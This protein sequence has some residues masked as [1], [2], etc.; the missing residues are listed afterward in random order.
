MRFRIRPS[1]GSRKSR[2]L[3]LPGWG[4]GVTVPIST[5]PKPSAFHSGSSWAPLSRPAARPMGER[6]RR[7]K[8][9]RAMAGSWR[10]QDALEQDRQAGHPLGQSAQ[11]EAKPVGGFRIQLEKQ[12]TDETVGIQGVSH[13]LSAGKIAISVMP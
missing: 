8:A 4:R 13:G 12:G 6:K 9:S 10:P 2:G 3:G 5:K 1:S 11:E 7:P